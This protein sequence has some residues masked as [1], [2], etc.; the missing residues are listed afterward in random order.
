MT[1]L[2]ALA[3]V[4]GPLSM[5]IYLPVLPE[6]QRSFLTSNEV[7]QLSFSVYMLSMGIAQL[8][9][10]T[11]SDRFGRRPLMLAGIAIFIVGSAACA[12]AP[13]IE[14]LIAARALQAIGGGSGLVLARAILSDLYPP[15]E[16]ARRFAF[17][18]LLMLVG[19]TLGPLLGGI[20]AEFGGWRL[21]FWFLSGAGVFVFLMLLQLLP[22]TLR[23]SDAAQSSG[24][25]GGWKLALQEKRFLLYGAVSTFSLSAYYVFIS[26]AP[27]LTA[28]LFSTSP[29]EFGQYFIVLALAYGCGNF[30]ATRLTVR[31]G[32]KR[33]VFFG[34]T[35]ALSGGVI[36]AALVVAGF[37]SPL[38][39][40]LPMAIITFA[41]GFS[42]P[43][44]QAGAIA[45]VPEHAGAASSLVS[46]AMQ[47]V[48]AAIAQ[49]VASTSLDTPYPLTGILLLLLIGSYVAALRIHRTGHPGRP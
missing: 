48:G 36:L 49:L 16:M 3:V 39:L 44:T 42:G 19:P 18:I 9:I 30:T 46:F 10:G 38:G 29:R 24:L 15:A 20:I 41:H 17:V 22:E 28:A 25:L 35:I 1:L 23:K 47:F 2:L 34:M 11:L 7:T 27:F 26:I 40:F 21:I 6:V 31:L 13:G 33:T 8:F 4:L 43:S 45:Q 32:I 5:Q 12:L 37:W 14:W